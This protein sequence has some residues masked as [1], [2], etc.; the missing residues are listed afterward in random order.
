MYEKIASSSLDKEYPNTLIK[1]I[2]QNSM[3]ISKNIEKHVLE[4]YFEDAYYKIP[5][6]E[7]EICGGF[8]NYETGYKSMF[9]NII[10]YFKINI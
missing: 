2:G 1:R 9:N 7:K 3:N 10:K 4:L 6:E 5:Q 8:L